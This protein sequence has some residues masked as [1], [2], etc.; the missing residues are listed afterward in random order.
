MLP[1]APE[2]E[3]LFHWKASRTFCHAI[4]VKTSPLAKTLQSMR[5]MTEIRT[6]DGSFSFRILARDKADHLDEVVAE[7][8]LEVDLALQSLDFS[9]MGQERNHAILKVFMEVARTLVDAEGELRCE[10]DD[11]QEDP[12]FEFFTIKQGQLLLQRGTLVREAERIP[13]V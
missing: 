9:W 4:G 11:D 10:I 12:H 7:A 6:Y 13:Q 1:D 2:G 5:C 8:G 3:K